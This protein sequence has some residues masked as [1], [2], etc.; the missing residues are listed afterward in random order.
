M[1]LRFVLNNNAWE[2]DQSRPRGLGGRSLDTPATHNGMVR[3]ECDV[4]SS[5]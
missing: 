1:G 5:Y 4:K 3:R 2:E